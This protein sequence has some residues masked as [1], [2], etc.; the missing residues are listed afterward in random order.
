M[1]SFGQVE[2]NK[3]FISF[4]ES[5]G[6]DRI[7]N[8]PK[9]STSLYVTSVQQERGFHGHL[10]LPGDLVSTFQIFAPVV[11]EFVHK[12]PKHCCV[13]FL[14]LSHSLLCGNDVM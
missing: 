4:H 3:V 5:R 13:L 7:K 8:A 12:V 9:D 2:R 10:V 6:D 11:K 1:P 14:Q